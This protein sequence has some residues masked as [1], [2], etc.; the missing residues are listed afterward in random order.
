MQATE[1]TKRTY[2]TKSQKIQLLNELKSGDMTI[3][4]LARKHGV[5]PVTIHKWKRE[6]AKETDKDS[7]DVHELLA[8]LEKIKEENNHLKKAVGD[9]AVSK[10]ILQ[11]AVEVLK[12]NQRSE[13][14]KPRKK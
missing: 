11:T 4:T 2:R 14:L 5:H 10:E 12:K 9:M 6:M 8:E 13:K 1:T 3:S 7:I